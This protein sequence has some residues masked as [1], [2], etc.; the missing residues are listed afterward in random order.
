MNSD[1]GDDLLRHLGLQRFASSV[2]CTSIDELE[3]LMT[4]PEGMTEEE[5]SYLGTAL[6]AAGKSFEWAVEVAAGTA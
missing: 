2:D 1:S 3:M 6:V 5:Y 4:A